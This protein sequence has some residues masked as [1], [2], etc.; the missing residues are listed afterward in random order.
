MTLW[1]PEGFTGRVNILQQIIS[2]SLQMEYES[3]IGLEVHAQLLTDSKIAADALLPMEKL[4]TLKP[5]R[6]AWVS[7]GLCRF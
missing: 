6:F 2:I 7:L 3:I 4:Q 5:V 1:K